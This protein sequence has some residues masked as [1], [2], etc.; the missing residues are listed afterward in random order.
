MPQTT[1]FDSTPPKAGRLVFSITIPGRLPSWNA[2][3]GMEHWARYQFK[4]QLADAFLYELQRSARDCSTRTTLQRS[5]ML[6][7]ADTLALYLTTA[8]AKRKS[9][10]ASKR[11]SRGL[12]KKSSLKSFKPTE[13][14]PF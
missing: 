8:Q 10:S 14:P 4:K 7:Y 9:K 5:I 6:T 2:I 3:L 13:P 11:Q 12:P 1:F